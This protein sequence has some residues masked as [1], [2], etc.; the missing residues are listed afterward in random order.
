MSCLLSDIHYMI[1][2]IS[3]SEG[4]A[5]EGL[6]LAKR[7]GSP[8][9]L[10]RLVK[11]SLIRGDFAL[12]DKYLGILGR[13]PGYRRWAEK[14]AGYIR[15]PEKIGQDGELAAKTIPVFQ[16]D[17]LLCL[18]G[19]DSLWFGHLSEPGVN[20]VAWEYLGCSYLLAKEMEKFKIFLSHAGR[21]CRDSPFL[22]IFRRR[23]WFWRLRTFLSLTGFP[24]GLR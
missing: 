12:A 7:G 4:Y 24:S 8:R 11:I 10:Q 19:I 22:F 18:T 17:N 23:H 2:D 9:L 15:H 3:L 21:F 20:R 1:G 14:Y 16:P 13:L 6:T 5:M